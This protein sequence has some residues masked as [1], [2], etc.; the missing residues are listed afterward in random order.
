MKFIAV[1]FCLLSLFSCA[2]HSGPSQE[3]VVSQAPV[4]PVF[5]RL[6]ALH[7]Q[8]LVFRDDGVFH[9]YGFTYNS[10][11]ADWLQR[12][13]DFEQD[14]AT[15]E[16][17]RLLAGLSVAYRTHGAKS[18]I[19][20]QFED[21]FGQALRTPAAEKQAPPA[22][23][24]SEPVTLPIPEGT[25]RS[26]TLLFSGDTQG[27]VYSQPGGFGPVGGLARRPP[28]LNHF[29]AEDSGTVVLDAG[30]TFVAGF[31]KAEAINKALV[32]AM[33]HMRYDAMGLG[34]HDL[35]IG[36]VMLR[37]LASIA[38]F[39]MICSNL[40][41]QKGVEPWINPYVLIKRDQVRIALVSLLPPAPGVR[42]TGAKLIPPGQALQT[43]LPELK[44]KADCI[45]LL[46]QFGTEAISELLGDEGAV[47]V[48]LGDGNGKSGENP[49]Y[50]PAVPKGLGFGLVRLKKADDG[51]FR[52]VESLPV[53]LGTASDE[54]VLQI[55]EELK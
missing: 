15:G 55:M 24:V 17:A 48:V 52:P 53:L 30:D 27:V 45:V 25:A 22:V 4:L 10:P 11:Y 49:A 5:E 28:T 41:F 6:H 12:V 46:T 38:S 39:P 36:E 20:R 43:M 3:P 33:N 29:L 37:E 31:A 14:P 9:R 8:F 35:A 54:H 51:D 42:I 34:P 40:Q 44:G 47:D 16:A 7:E 1:L 19:Y 32:R 18:R 13:R 26:I 2:G 21:R 50:L 23:V